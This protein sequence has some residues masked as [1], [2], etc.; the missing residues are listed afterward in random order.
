L[1][2]VLVNWVY[3]RTLGHQ[4]L[5]G[6]LTP[7][8]DAARA[9]M[10]PVGDR[11][12]ALTISVSTFGFLNLTMLAP[13]R[14]YYAMARDGVFLSSVSRLHPRFRSPTRAIFL[15][16]ALAVVLLF[17]KDYAQLV[18]YVV[19]ADWIFFGLAGASLFVFR[20]RIPLEARPPG[21]FRTPGYPVLPALF[22]AVA[23]YIVSTSFVSD[24]KGSFFGVL[25]LATGIPAFLFWKKRYDDAETLD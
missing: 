2:Y 7:A 24:P 16:T 3:L 8:A 5:A 23:L 17:W 19:F 20:R 6:T 13:T 10:G 25:L 21:T 18:D 9:T 15:Q 11:F 22:T 12:L 4:G 1:V 14:V